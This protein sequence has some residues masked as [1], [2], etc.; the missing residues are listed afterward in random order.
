MTA[1]DG[2][3]LLPALRYIA[4]DDGNPDDR[5]VAE[6]ILGKPVAPGE[7]ISVAI[8]FVSRLPRVSVRTGYKDDFFMVVQWFPKL[9]VFAGGRA[10]TATR[11]TPPP[12]STP[13]SGTTTPRSPS[14]G[15]WSS[16]PP[17]YP[18]GGPSIPDGT[19]Q[20]PLPPG[21]RHR[22]RLDGV[23][24]LRGGEAT[25]SAPRACPRSSSSLLVPA[26]PLRTRPRSSSTRPKAMLFGY[27]GRHWLP[28]PY[29]RLTVVA[30]PAEAPVRRG[31]DGV[32]DA[33]HRLRPERTR[34]P[35]ATSSSGR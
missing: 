16:E 5:T 6:V 31:G 29:P 17:E 28:Y 21:R 7:T 19:V 23:G 25:P 4:P 32:P 1:S 8:E 33:L 27:G 3:D 18:S 2:A 15:R 11:S 12:S 9:G 26:R 10:G 30:P 14:L 35:R 34:S 24:G 22:L 13:T 20:P